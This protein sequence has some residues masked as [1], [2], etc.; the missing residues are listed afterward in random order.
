MATTLINI[1]LNPFSKILTRINHMMLINMSLNIAKLQEDL[2]NINNIIIIIIIIMTHNNAD[3]TLGF[4]N[5]C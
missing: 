2:Q 5:Y 4:I 3:S 1:I